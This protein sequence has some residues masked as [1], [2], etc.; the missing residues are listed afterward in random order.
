M[1]AP[2]SYAEFQTQEVSE[3][4]GLAIVEAARK[5]VGWSL[6]SGSVYKRT[7]FEHSV[8][9]RIIENGTTY[10]QVYSRASVVASTFYIDRATRTIYL[11]TSD[12]SNPNSKFIG[13]V[14]QFFFSNVAGIAAPHDLSAG[15]EVEWLPLI[16]K[17][18]QFSYELDNQYQLGEA[19]EGGGKIEFHADL[20][21]W[22]S[23]F[24]KLIWENQRV[25]VYSW[26]RAL[27]FTEA[28]IIF[29]G[30]IQGKE[31]SPSDKVSFTLKDTINATRGEV[32]LPLMSE[33]VGVRLPDGEKEKKQRR[34]YGRIDG[35][36][37]INTDQVLDGYPCTGTVSVAFDSTNLVG[38]GTSFLS[39]LAPDDEIIVPGLVDS[40]R[41][42]TIIDDTTAT[43]SEKAQVAIASASFTIKPEAP[44]RWM[45]RTW[46]V[47][48]H[49]LRE[50]TAV[51]TKVIKLNMLKVDSTI[52]LDV[53][54]EVFINGEF[55][56]LTRVSTSGLVKL[57][58]NLSSRPAIGD[59]LT[60]LSVSSVRI[61]DRALRYG[62]DYD[63]DATAGTLTLDELAEFNVT[64]ISTPAGTVTL[65][66]GSRTVTGV[67]TKFRDEFKTDD[68]IRVVGQADWF[69]I[70]QVVS[71]TQMILRSPATYTA[72]GTGDAKFPKIYNSE[73]D[74][75]SASVLGKTEDGTPSGRLLATAA[76]IVKDL[77]ADIG[78]ASDI[79]ASSFTAA[80]SITEHKLGLT[81]PVM[82]EDSE[83]SEVRDIIG[84]I[85]KSVFGSLIQS[86]DFELQYQVLSPARSAGSVTKFREYDVL[87]F[88]VESNV[89]RI[90]SRATVRYGFKQY[91]YL[92]RGP[93][94]PTKSAAS[95]IATYLTKATQEET[96]DTVLV[97]P[98]DA[99]I[100]AYRWAF[101]LEVA[102]SVVMI[103]TKLQGARLQAT[104]KI[105]LSHEKL[106]ER[107]GGGTRKIAGIQ[108]AAKDFFDVEISIED[109]ANAFTRAG[110]ITEN[111]APDFVSSRDADKLYSG[112]VTD[113]YGMQGND[114]E[115][116][117]TSLIW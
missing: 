57:S 34:I 72:S 7:S 39:E 92:S 2:T 46:F 53:G 51:V 44:K 26:N 63:Y 43:I 74:T 18:G 78:L 28:K 35:F 88:S 55:T 70:M 94:Y 3:K 49:A 81:V 25:R 73:I 38:T 8:I 96:I 105:D 69:E 40:V 75:V 37:P 41:I 54:T 61:N 9:S 98:I 77:L 110:V 23:R 33:L 86:R 10:T 67:G 99:Q 14:G 85:N 36:V 71:D 24:D 21:F 89:D 83:I 59:T 113:S 32:Q 65:T 76:P 100:M 5:L 56:T 106:Y 93:S 115:T 60:R 64:P 42:A 12:S 112:Y 90:C 29:K 6:D 45:N 22:Q 13:C 68:W 116:Y 20:E 48:G 4:V 108:R 11:Q 30:F 19:L 97:N 47:A 15:F 87:D 101:I 107:I 31:F 91:D 17:C 84:I 95:E 16:A 62:R 111:D 27:P 114:P 117:G 58:T 66:N 102:S 104:D 50:P 80:E 103:K 1:S 82:I 79:D 109:L 52:D